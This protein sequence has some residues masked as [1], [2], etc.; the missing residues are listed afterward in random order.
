MSEPKSA[1]NYRAT[2]NAYYKAN[3][4]AINKAKL[5][6]AI[7]DGKRSPS[8]KTLKKFGLLDDDVDGKC[9]TITINNKPKYRILNDLTTKPD[10]I[11]VVAKNIISPPQVFNP[12]TAEVT[13]KDI[14][15]WCRQDEEALFKDG[16]MRSSKTINDYSALPYKL[17]LIRNLAQVLLILYG[18]HHIHMQQ[19]TCVQLWLMHLT[20]PLVVYTP[21]TLFIVPVE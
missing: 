1:N 16:K 9:N 15:N 11:N 5:I 7:I 8:L 19:A 21:T 3:S 20:R 10:V 14:S 12:A 2:K 4:F 18:R 6:K 13:G 17:S